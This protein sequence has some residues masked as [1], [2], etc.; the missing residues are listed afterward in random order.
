M[1]AY[2]Q[3]PNGGGVVSAPS[4]DALVAKY[5]LQAG[6]SEAA[7]RD[8]LRTIWW[9][10][11][12][13]APAEPARRNRSYTLAQ[14]L[15]GATAILRDAV[16][17]TVPMDEAI[18]RARICEACPRRTTAPDC[19][20]CGAYA[21]VKTAVQNLYQRP[22]PELGMIAT[23]GCDV[24]GCAC[25]LLVWAKAENFA[26]DAAQHPDRPGTCWIKGIAP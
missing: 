26:G 23:A 16:G 24:C 21:R 10:A 25:S 17:D 2:A 11:A 3:L 9:L 8:L 19:G 5:A 22:L 6:M 7:A 14:L 18:R 15:N 4:F 1:T 13:P 20:A 12:G